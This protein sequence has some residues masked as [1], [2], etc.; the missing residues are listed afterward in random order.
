MHSNI[1][2]LK[3]SWTLMKLNNT[4]CV[5]T[6]LFY[7]ILYERQKDRRGFLSTG[8][9]SDVYNGRDWARLMPAAVHTNQLCIR[10]K[11]SVNWPNI[12][13]PWV[14]HRRKLE[15]AAGTRNPAWLPILYVGILAS[16][17]SIHFFFFNVHKVCRVLVVTA[18]TRVTVIF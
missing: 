10:I 4:I 17:L 14:R 15:S 5:G 6:V 18:H 3:L 12:T 13:A 9:M 1:W 11:N 7:F 16:R 8:S 2:E